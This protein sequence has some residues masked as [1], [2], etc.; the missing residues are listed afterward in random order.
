MSNK[1]V[2]YEDR[3]QQRDLRIGTIEE[4]EGSNRFRQEYR[5]LR[6][7]NH[8]GAHEVRDVM[9]AR[10]LLG[11]CAFLMVCSTWSGATGFMNFPLDLSLTEC[12]QRVQ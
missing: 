11:M 12:S 4:P 2:T 3:S 1:F 5:A 7:L 10:L 8:A 9:F 6:R